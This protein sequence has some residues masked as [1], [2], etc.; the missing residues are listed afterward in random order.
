MASEEIEHG[1]DWPLYLD[2]EST[3]RIRGIELPVASLSP[4]SDQHQEGEPFEC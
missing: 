2:R 4:Q 1:I 3:V